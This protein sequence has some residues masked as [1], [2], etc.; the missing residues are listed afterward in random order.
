MRASFPGPA[1]A[2]RATLLGLVQPVDDRL[3]ETARAG[4]DA[5][6]LS[7]VWKRAQPRE[8][9]LDED[10]LD[11]VRGRYD[12]MRAAGLDVVLQPG[13]QY[14]PDWVFDL[15]D[16][17]RFVDQH[18]EVWEGE[19]GEETADAVHD[20]AVREAQAD[21]L[22]RLADA[23]GRGAFTAVRVG[24]LLDGELRYPS[25]R[26]AGSDDS[27]W[28]FN[29]LAQEGSPVPGWEP[30]DDGE[31][32]ARRFL[33][34]YLD[35]LADYQDFLV[36]VTAEAFDGDLYVLY[37]S[38]GVRPGEVSAAA[39]DRLRGETPGEQRQT[40]QLGVD[41]A[42]QVQRLADEPRAVAYSTWVD[43]RSQGP[44]SSDL[45]PAEYLAQVAREHG[46][47]VAGE[48]TG[49]G[50]RRDMERA[51]ERVDALDLV[52][53]FWFPGDDLFD[54]DSP[55]LEDLDALTE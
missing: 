10:Y 3:E 55:T 25:P 15:S 28:A 52:A 34:D 16:S 27:W 53:L 51:V 31:E 8:G 36:E 30:G 46:V 17:T 19:T 14:T 29:R 40:L 41:Y 22:R 4:V 24:G 50:G 43:A 9:G 54:G 21:Y 5:V 11:E 13:L 47:R 2:A 18:G 20:P 12:A 6:V 49:G 1:P 42:R 23:L 32:Q 48:N 38:W 35:D 44:S 33:D 7:V 39:E 26:G 45:A 37:P